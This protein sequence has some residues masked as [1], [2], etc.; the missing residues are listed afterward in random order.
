LLTWPEPTRWRL[1]ERGRL[2]M[3]QVVAE[4]TA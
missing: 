2:L 1:T 4:L 3:N